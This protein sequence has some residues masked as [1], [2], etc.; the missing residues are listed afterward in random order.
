[1]GIFNW[2]S[3][4]NTT[5]QPTNQSKSK[6]SIDQQLEEWEKEIKANQ[7]NYSNQKTSATT[8]NSSLSGVKVWVSRLTIA[9]LFVGIPLGL[10]WITNLPY[11]AIRR[12]VYNRF[13]LLLLPSQIYIDNN[14]KQ[15]VRFVAKGRQLVEGATSLEDILLAQEELQK[16]Q[17]YLDGIP[18][19]PLAELNEKGYR[20]SSGRLHLSF[21]HFDL[22]RLRAD[23]GE[24]DAK[25]FQENNAHALLNQ[26]QLAIETAE[27]KYQQSSTEA[28]K[29]TA[30]KGWKNAMNEL[31][32][33]PPSTLASQNAQNQYTLAQ[34]KFAGELGDLF[35][36]EQLQTYITIAEEFANQAIILADNPPHSNAKWQ[37]VEKFWQM[38][39]DELNSVP[40]DNLL[41]Y[42]KSRQLAAQYKANLAQIRLKKDAQANSAIAFNSAQQKIANLQQQNKSNSSNVEQTIS[43]LQD[44]INELNKVESGTSFYQESQDLKSFANQKIAQLR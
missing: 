9:S 19:M 43:Q 18:F 24:L 32:K 8:T 10:L 11:P 7:T 1:M 16:A 14:Y 38:S 36:D 26:A 20:Y 40:K 37:E 30:I 29:Q 5:N 4:K 34:E 15:S 13:P 23:V 33:V 6:R 39:I 25:I 12:P 3:R 27:K 35:V 28:E 42:Q 2:S 41:A 22:Q 31:R 44:I 21:S 17:E